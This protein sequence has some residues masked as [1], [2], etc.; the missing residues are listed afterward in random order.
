[1]HVQYVTSADGTRHSKGGKEK[2]QSGSPLLHLDAGDVLHDGEVV[3][4]EYLHECKRTHDAEG[5]LHHRRT[6]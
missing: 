5:I 1:M 4:A 6:A 2:G 3:V